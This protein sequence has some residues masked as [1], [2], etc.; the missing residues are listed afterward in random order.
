MEL[1]VRMNVM[2]VGERKDVS[3]EG[4]AKI[5]QETSPVSVRQAFQEDGICHTNFVHVH[6]S[7]FEHAKKVEIVCIFFSR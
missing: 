4:C 3:M 7:F 6:M 5:C 2:T 1:T